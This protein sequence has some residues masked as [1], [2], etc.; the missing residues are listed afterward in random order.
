MIINEEF[1]MAIA[2][3]V[4]VGMGYV[5]RIY[6]RKYQKSRDPSE[7][8]QQVLSIPRESPMTLQNL[9]EMFVLEKTCN[10]THDGLCNK[11]DSLMRQIDEHHTDNTAKF[12]ELFTLIRN[13]ALTRGSKFP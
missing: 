7:Q 3:A 11:M 5:G 12:A 10:K 1:I 2:T 6:H 4:G 8:N 9:M 13:S